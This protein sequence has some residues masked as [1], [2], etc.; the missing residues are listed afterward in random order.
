[1]FEKGEIGLGEEFVH[2]GVIGTLFRGVVVEETTVGD[3]SAVIPAISGSA[4]ITGFS[5]FVL[6]PR[7]TLT[8][9]FLLR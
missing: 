7:D 3:R 5:T 6:D 4:H 2:E 1:M 9:G 8:E